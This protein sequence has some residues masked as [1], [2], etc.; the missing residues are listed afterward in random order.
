MVKLWWVF[1]RVLGNN[2]IKDEVCKQVVSPFLSTMSY[3]FWF[4]PNFSRWIFQ[5]SP[6][7]SPKGGCLCLLHYFKEIICSFVM[8]H[9]VGCGFSQWSSIRFVFLNLQ[10]WEIVLSSEFL[11][12]VFF[13]GSFSCGHTASNSTVS[14]ETLLE[15]WGNEGRTD[16]WTRIWKVGLHKAL[17]DIMLNQNAWKQPHREQ[18]YPGWGCQ[19]PLSD[20]FLAGCAGRYPSGP[21]PL[22]ECSSSHYLLHSLNSSVDWQPSRPFHMQ[23]WKTE[24]SGSQ[25][26]PAG[27]CAL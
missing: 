15:R 4:S 20:C 5:S 8:K 27:I 6:E 13:F 25:S 22:S 11:V 26:V 1:S 12:G 23:V 7:W 14:G 2:S 10:L 21:V 16:M 17:R 9:V 24:V 18:A 19:S 3:N